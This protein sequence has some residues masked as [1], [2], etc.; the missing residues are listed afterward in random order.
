MR[1]RRES[2]RHEREA[3]DAERERD[4]HAE[5]HGRENERDVAPKRE[6]AT[7]ESESERERERAHAHASATWRGVP[8]I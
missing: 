8:L 6:R 7:H 5:V 3:R 4:V 1:E 2:P